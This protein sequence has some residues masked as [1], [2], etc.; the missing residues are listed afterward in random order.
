MVIGLSLF[1]LIFVLMLLGVP[2]YLSLGAAGT[3]GLFMLQN[4]PLLVIPQ[5]LYT[6]IGFFPLLAIPFF[7]LAG[8]LMNKGGITD[9]LIDFARMLIGKTPASLANANVIACMFFGGVTGSAQADTSAIG[10]VMIPA[11]I[12]DGYTP[13][14][15]AALTAAASTCGPI[16]PP[17]I[18]M[19]IYCVTVGGSVGTM[20]MAGIVPGVLIALGLIVAVLIMD[21]KYH[22]PRLLENIPTREKIRITV[23]ALWPLGMPVIIVGGIIGGIVTPTEAGAMAVVYALI[24]GLLILRT[25]HLRDLIPMLK[26]TAFLSSTILMIISCAKIL[27]WVLTEVQVQIYLGQLFQA[28]SG[29]STIIFLMLVN[30][31]LLIMG[32]FMDGGVSI[33]IL[34]PILAPIAASLGINPIHF[35]LIMVLNLVIG[36]GTPPL[37]LCLFI[38]CGIAKIPVDRGARAIVPFL[39]A[40]VAVLL[41]VTYVPQTVLFIPKLLGYM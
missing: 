1:V 17:S 13:E 16:V 3:V 7:I 5:S 38:G 12:K 29:N 23:Q 2:I 18:M 32:T 28:L 25:L 10:G 30:I 33:I 15:S 4:N 8:E 40:E 27:G 35:G 21:R 22:F 39:V 11:M 31:L 36:C 19:V 37:G 24:V 14:F 6:Q 41:L 20:F 34:A 26:S 9:R